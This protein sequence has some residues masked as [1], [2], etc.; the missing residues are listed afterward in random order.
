MCC[1]YFR[2]A[3]QVVLNARRSG[4]FGIRGHSVTGQISW[5]WY[6]P[7]EDIEILSFVRY[8]SCGEISPL[9]LASHG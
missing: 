1:I 9:A 6:R 5:H 7:Y 2:E 3:R 4:N 8:I